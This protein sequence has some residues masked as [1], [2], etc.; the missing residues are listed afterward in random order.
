MA[1]DQLPLFQRKTFQVTLTQGA[2]LKSPTPDSSI[3]S[4]LPAYYAYLQS[5]GYSPYTPGDFCGDI[6]KFGLFLP[7]KKLQEITEQDIRHWVSLLRTQEKMTEKTI[8]RKLSALNNY[9]TWLVTEHVLTH[10]PALAIPNGKVISPLPEIL[11]EEECNRLVAAANTDARTYLLVLLLLET[12]IKTEELMDLQLSQIDT[13]NKYAPEVWVKH[14]GKKIKKDRKLKLPPEIIPVLADYT[15][16]YQITD[17]LFPFTQ[18]L[19]RYLLRTV[20]EQAKLKK[21]VSAQLL[22][23]TCAV[24]LL[25]AG[26]PIETVLRKLGLSETTWED[27]REKYLKLIS[28]AL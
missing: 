2:A 15:N 24:R 8:S 20:G 10:N 13:S 18:R 3:L 7:Q 26:E 27:A 9:C 16:T 12:G 19:M 6:R 17:Q 14:S 5:Q 22:R 25:K 23:D 28:R 21:P 11:F 1:D 4:T